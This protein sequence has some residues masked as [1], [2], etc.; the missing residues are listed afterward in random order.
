MILGQR[1][2]A[3]N[4]AHLKFM[5]EAV[6]H[7]SENDGH[8]QELRNQMQQTE[9]AYKKEQA[10]VVSMQRICDQLWLE[11]DQGLSAITATVAGTIAEIN[12][13]PGEEIPQ[14]TVIIR[15]Q[16]QV[17]LSF[18]LSSDQAAK[19]TPGQEM[20]INFAD[21]PGKIFSGK[22]SMVEN[23]LMTI[24]LNEPS[25]SILVTMPPQITIF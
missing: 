16:G 9:G 4:T 21:Y 20:A 22:V 23:N 14:R 6:G 2:E 19:F 3:F 15:T 5:T 17:K 8:Y 18:V 1:Q 13:V 24:I 10:L 25:D 11:Y 12:L 7:L